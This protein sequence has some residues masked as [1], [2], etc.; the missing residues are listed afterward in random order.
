MALFGL[1]FR[2]M[3]NLY[4]LFCGINFTFLSNYNI[5]HLFTICHEHPVPVDKHDSDQCFISPHGVKI[6]LFTKQGHV[7]YQIKGN[8]ECSNMVAN[9]LTADPHPHPDPGDGVKRS[10]FK[11]FKHHTAYQIKGN[12]EMQQHGNK[13]FTNRPP[14]P[15]I[16]TLGMGSIGQ[17][18]TLSEHDHVAYQIKGNY[19]MQKQGSTQFANR[20]PATPLT[21]GM[22][23]MGQNLPFSEHGHIA[24]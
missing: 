21:L 8:H 7:A 18:K 5:W 16:P 23:S 11:F 9:I 6:Q 20:P 19:E 17:N 4:W 3:Q 22:G 14:T 13:Y 12:N 2:L 1:R 10:K 24:Y 15:I